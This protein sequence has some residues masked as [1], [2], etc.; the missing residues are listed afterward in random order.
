MDPIWSHANPDDELVSRLQTILSIREPVARL[1]VNRGITDSEQADT[2]LDGRLKHLPD[3]FLLSGMRKAVERVEK[4]IRKGEKIVAWGDYDADG[5][6][7]L[8]L[9]ILFFRE[10]PY[11]LDYAIPRRREDGYGLQ[12]YSVRE[13]AGAGTKLIVTV[14]NGITSI[15]E[16]ETARELGV[17][18]IIIDHHQLAESLPNAAAVIDPFRPDCRFPE[19]TLCAAG[20]T[21][22]FLM[23]LRRH[24]VEKEILAPDPLPNLKNLLDIVTIGTVADMVP[25]RGVN[26]LFVRHGLPLLSRSRRPGILALKEVSRLDIDGDVEAGDVGFRLAPRL[27]AGGRIGD[28]RAGVDLLVTED[29][30]EARRHAQTLDKRNQQRKYFQQIVVN[31][32]LQSIETRD[33]F[34]N[35]P[36]LVLS[37]KG[38]QEGVVGLAASKVVEKTG[39]PAVVIAI[40]EDGTARGSCRSIENYHIQQAL[41]RQAEFL[42]RFGGHAQAAGLTIRE[43]RIEDFRRAL[44]ADAG[45]RLSGNDFRKVLHT[46]GPCDLGDVDYELLDQIERLAPFGMSNPSP[47]FV[48]SDVE[49]VQA[50]LR[51][52]VHW[53]LLLRKNGRQFDAIAFNM[54]HRPLSK[55]DR[56]DIAYVPE[57]NKYKGARTVQL[58]IK[59]LKGSES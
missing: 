42:E 50:G 21:F 47:L 11:D 12:E 29:L 40:R 7:S 1:L 17:D 32:C 10:I 44:V 22:L 26:R 35:A 43:E 28:A 9:L 52:E 36:I 18:V 59:D 45:A 14:D 48:D 34:K 55:G 2:F 39:R 57:Y 16:V 49:V 58:R 19:K 8:S 6:T 3:P 25:L 51:K 56:L 31:E 38:W 54:G 20:L 41:E 13:L 24:L 53:K 23:A 33:E 15:R 4:A 27:N 46:D 37:G 30:Q 5:I